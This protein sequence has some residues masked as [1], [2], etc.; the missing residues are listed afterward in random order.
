MYKGKSHMKRWL[1]IMVVVLVTFSFRVVQADTG[2]PIIDQQCPC[3]KDWKSHGEYVSCV[4]T[5][6]PKIVPKQAIRQIITNA[7]T[8]EC[9]GKK[10]GGARTVIGPDGGTLAIPGIATI[11]FPPN[12][13][14][15]ATT[16]MMEVTSDP[17]TDVVYKESTDMFL[18]GALRTNEIRVRA[19][20][21]PKK[22]MI[23]LM[24]TPAA[25]VATLPVD[26]S[27]QL[28]AQI[29]QQ[30]EEEVHDIF[31]VIDSTF[32]SDTRIVTANLPR[33]VFTDQRVP[34]LAEA[35]FILGTTP[36]QSSNSNTTQPTTST[37]QQLQLLSSAVQTAAS[38]CPV[39]L[40]SPFGGNRV[41]PPC[42]A[43]KSNQPCVNR[44]FSDVATINPASGDPAPHLGT[45]IKADKSTPLYSSLNGTVLKAGNYLSGFGNRV[46][47]S[48][49]GVQVGY[50]HLE[51]FVVSE[52]QPIKTGDLIGYVDST[53]NSTGDHLHLDY[54][55]SGGV[56]VKKN[57]SDP[58][59]CLEA[60]DATSPWIGTWSGT[61]TSTCGAYSGPVTLTITSG[62]GNLLNFTSVWN[63]GSASFSGSY[64]GNTA[65]SELGS[66]YALNGNTI[67]VA[68][69]PACQTATVT[70]Q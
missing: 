21:K 11:T 29:Y 46:V 42:D 4:A 3:T 68:Y 39:K 5:T 40:T 25:F 10:N 36:I 2:N 6:A 12:S 9:G 20:G 47:I 33:A 48:G 49:G 34:G 63:G 50:S 44:P 57:R 27:I 17:Q 19:L 26:H 45:D 62:G 7:A 32:N 16:V 30:T 70:R 51:S 38:T 18:A 60:S 66:T 23:L 69:P 24:N 31:E 65:T 1:T 41:P 61:T 37:T 64:S 35:V 55:Q 15:Q 52:G 53:G 28:F 14:P 59:S 67:T 13:F 22:D 56:D 8:S 54:A 43:T 58:M